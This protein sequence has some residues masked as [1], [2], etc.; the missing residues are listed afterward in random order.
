MR[1]VIR[2]ESLSPRPSFLF[3]KT[4]AL[5]ICTSWVTMGIHSSGGQ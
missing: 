2:A 4:E 5:I 1:S 3:D